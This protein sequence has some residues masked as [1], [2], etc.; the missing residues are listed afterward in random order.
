MKI[1]SGAHQEENKEEFTN[2]EKI[3]EKLKNNT[4]LFGREFKYKKIELDESFPEYILRNKTKFNPW[5][6]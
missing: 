4:D 2:L 3:E 1:K 6:I 5:I